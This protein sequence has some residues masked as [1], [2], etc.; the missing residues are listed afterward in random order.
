MNF[1]V[2]VHAS[3]ITELKNKALMNELLKTR[4]FSYVILLKNSKKPCEAEEIYTPEVKNDEICWDNDDFLNLHS[5]GQN[6]EFKTASES[7]SD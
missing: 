2:S 6:V 4:C 1:A 5:Y 3:S 7:Q